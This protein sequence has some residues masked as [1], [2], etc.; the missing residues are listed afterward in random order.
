MR[1]SVRSV[2][3]VGAVLVG[4][5][6][7]ASASAAVGDDWPVWDAQAT[8]QFRSWVVEDGEFVWSNGVMQS[9]GANVDGLHHEDYWA[10]LIVGGEMPIDD[11]DD[12]YRHATWGAF[13]ID[14]WATDGD[15]ELPLDKGAW[16]DFTAELAELRVQ[17]DADEAF[18]RLRYTS[19][20]S[21][22]TQIATIGFAADDDDLPAPAAWP[23][24][25]D[26]RSSWDVALTVGGAGAWLQ[27][28]DG[29]V[30][31]AADAVRHG[32]H[33]VEVRIDRDL[34]P[35]GG[36][37]LTGGAGLADPAD[38]G[39][40]WPVP[41]G[42]AT[43]DTP[44][45]GST[46]A[47]SVP[48]WSLLFADDETWTFTARTEGDLLVDGDV[49]AAHHALDVAVLEAGGDA[50]PPL[51]TGRF[52]R[53]HESA[54]DL[55]DGIA[56]DGDQPLPSFLD[57]PPEVPLDDAAV[58]F[59]YTGRLQPYGMQVP[60]D[61]EDRDGPLPL[62]LYLHGANNY[63]Y[64]P[65]GVVT[66]LELAAERGYLFAGLLGRGDLGYAG[67]G[68]L[69]VLEVLADVQRTYD[70]DPSRVYLMGHSMGS[71][72]THRVAT[73]HPDL[74]AAIAPM[75]IHSNA[76]LFGN[77]RHVPYLHSTGATDVLDGG[78][79]GGLE[80]FEVMA[81]LGYDAT[82]Y[83]HLLKFHEASSTDDLFPTILD[84]YDRSQI[85]GD[86]ATITFRRRPPTDIEVE[87]GLLADGVYDAVQAL[88]F[89]DPTLDQQIDVESFAIP[90]APLDPANAEQTDEVVDEGGVSNRSLARKLV[91][92]PAYGAPVEVANR[93]TVA[94][95]NVASVDLVLD[96]L[97]LDPTTELTVATTS[98]GPATL[99][100]V[101]V[102][103][104]V[105]VDGEV[106]TASAGRVALTV[107]DGAH[108]FV[109][110]PAAAPEAPVDPPAPDTGAGGDGAPLPVTGGSSGLLAGALLLG[111]AA[112]SRRLRERVVP[113]L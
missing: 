44:G 9:R 32:D 39:T 41:T 34:L 51:R 108:E 106:V 83:H 100:L 76:D 30:A 70:V 45:S 87:L 28:A 90:H 49:Q 84:H 6:T 61:Y 68:E 113:S 20:P 57:L 21:P 101:G 42:S 81:N 96:E 110:R 50:A 72:G 111:A 63:Y 2:L 102:D 26:A 59:T 60:D 14:R 86:P 23:R 24:G 69:D 74:F 78:G 79:Q 65:F 1:T 58:G 46:I 92:V 17:V 56:R 93:V 85:P 98:D 104:A 75:Q 19:M 25:G 22:T 62:I 89:T 55:G 82:F 18:L 37:V 7:G 47:T 43:A 91:S 67:L 73:R 27:T 66:Q 103:S 38:P 109:L 29:E 33:T 36:W 64:E 48:V 35:D 31:L 112:T 53:F 107:P 5:G 40:Y 10:P 15:Y 12:V 4:A 11:R 80:A 16:P 94:L 13:G 8:N 71:S 52:A 95:E 54:V 97:H 77:L 99:T 3:L 88:T 105:E